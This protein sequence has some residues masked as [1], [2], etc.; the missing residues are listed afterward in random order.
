MKVALELPVVMGTLPKCVSL[1]QS[2]MVIDTTLTY[3]VILGRPFLYQIN[4]VITIRHLALKF[5]T[6]K[7]VAT[8]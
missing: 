6:L 2:F 1:Q 7:G 8:L 3:I 5:P 4:V